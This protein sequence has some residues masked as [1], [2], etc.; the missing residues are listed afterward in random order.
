MASESSKS[1]SAEV[2]NKKSFTIFFLRIAF[3]EIFHKCMENY[4]K[5]AGKLLKKSKQKCLLKNLIK[6]VIACELKKLSC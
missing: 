4:T 1:D 6:K 2:K 3:I 5:N